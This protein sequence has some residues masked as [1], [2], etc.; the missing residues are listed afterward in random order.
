MNKTAHNDN[1]SWPSSNAHNFN[2]KQLLSVNFYKT[3]FFISTAPVT[4]SKKVQRICVLH[5]LYT[6]QWSENLMHKFCVNIL[7]NFNSTTIYW[8][9]FKRCRF[10]WNC[11]CI[12]SGGD[13]LLVNTDQ[14]FKLRHFCWIWYVLLGSA[15]RPNKSKAHFKHICFVIKIKISQEMLLSVRTVQ[16]WKPWLII[17][18]GLDW[19]SEYWHQFPF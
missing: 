12:V 17:S 4:R 8:C 2:V 3:R 16:L 11:H 5:H 6:M 9:N 15:P 10:A 19:L 18:I 7:L 13:Q 1:N 14:I